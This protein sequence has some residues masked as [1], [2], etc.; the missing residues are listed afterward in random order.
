MTDTHSTHI[1]LNKTNCIGTH[2][3]NTHSIHL[4]FSFEF[5]PIVC[6]IWAKIVVLC[7]SLYLKYVVIIDVTMLNN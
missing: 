6:K 2:T 3:F 7:L 1:Q 5:A 4:F